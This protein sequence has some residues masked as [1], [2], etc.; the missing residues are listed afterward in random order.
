M[1]DKFIL[2]LLYVLGVAEGEAEPDGDELG[3]ALGLADDLGL[4]LGLALGEAFGLAL[5]CVEAD[6]VA[7]RLAET[8]ALGS[9][10]TNTIL[11]SSSLPSGS[12][13]TTAGF[14]LSRNPNTS[15]TTTAKTAPPTKINLPLLDPFAG[16][17]SSIC[18][19]II[20]ETRN[21]CG[22]NQTFRL[23]QPQ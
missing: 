7:S 14:L 18:S 12:G 9:G 11:T 16:L 15:S 23:N 6:G 10:L 21:S 4:A 5:D 19:P 8:V 13:E 2:L 17:L 20:H 1:A 3:V 22:G